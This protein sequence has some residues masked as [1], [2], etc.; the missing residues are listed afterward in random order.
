VR[1]YEAD[2]DNPGSFISTW[3]CQISD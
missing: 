3:S 1:F 2:P